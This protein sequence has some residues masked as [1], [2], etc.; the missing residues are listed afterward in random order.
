MFTKDLPEG[1][2]TGHQC[3]LLCKFLMPFLFA[4]KF[5]GGEGSPRN[6]DLSYRTGTDLFQII[7]GRETLIL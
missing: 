3:C 7:F 5:K 4:C 6:L 2:P 1:V